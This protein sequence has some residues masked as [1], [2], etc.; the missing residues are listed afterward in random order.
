[1]EQHSP[2]STV[3]LTWYKEHTNLVLLNPAMDGQRCILNNI[4]D[5][6]NEICIFSINVLHCTVPTH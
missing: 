5:W 1:M 2:S 4:T 6:K 3:H